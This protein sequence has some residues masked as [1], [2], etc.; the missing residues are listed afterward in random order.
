MILRSDDASGII[1]LDH[2]KDVGVFANGKKTLPGVLQS[3]SIG[4]EII[5]D[6]TNSVSNGLS[7]KTLRG[8][9]CKS[10]NMTLL[11]IST[12]EKTV[13]QLL[14]ELEEI[15]M[16]KIDKTPLVITL[17]NPHTDSRG[18]TKVLFTGFSSSEDN[19]TE[20]ITITL[21]FEEFLITKDGSETKKEA[22]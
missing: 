8:Y 11:L 15:F 21:N 12:A 13:Y 14:E 3:L 18:I 6:S 19:T 16:D 10:V 9:K 2:E 4:G 5:I 1:T 22:T 17:S 7:T 20:T